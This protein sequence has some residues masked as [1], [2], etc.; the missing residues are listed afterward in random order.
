MSQPVVLA[1]RKKN[2]VGDGRHSKGASCFSPL[3]LLHCHLEDM[4]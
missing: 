2:A 4:G 3:V 1:V